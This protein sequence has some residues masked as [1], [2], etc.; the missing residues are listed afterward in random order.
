MNRPVKTKG[1]TMQ[2]F[3]VDMIQ[4]LIDALGWTQKEVCAYVGC[5]E[6]SMTR[7]LKGRNTNKLRPVHRSKFIELR[8][9]LKGE[10]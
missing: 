5:S 7:W 1:V 2:V 6:Q 8:N 9:Q 10:S 4:E 3:T